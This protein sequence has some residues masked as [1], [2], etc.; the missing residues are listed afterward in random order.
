MKQAKETRFISKLNIQLIGITFLI[1]SI[2]IMNFY[3]ASQGQ[4]TFWMHTLWIFMGIILFFGL[5]SFN[6]QL[7]PRICYFFYG[8]NVLALI[9]VLFI[10]SSSHGSQRW[11]DLGLFSFQPSETMKIILIC[12]LAHLLSKN[13]TNQVYGF[14]DVI[15]PSIFVLPPMILIA[16][17]PDLG[18]ALIIGIQSLIVIF[19][20]KLNRNLW[21]S[22]GVLIVI[23]VPIMWNFA[24]KDYQKSRV[25]TFLSSQND[26]SGSSYNIIQSKI[27]IGSGQV[28]GKGLKKGTQTQLRFIPE[29]QTDFI[30]SVLSEEHGFIGSIIVL[31]LFLII[32]LNI[33]DTAGQSRDKLGVFICI[34]CASLVFCQVLINVGM[35][36][37]LFPVVGIPLPLLSYG[38]SNMM[39]IFITLGLVSSVYTHKF[40]YSP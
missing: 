4:S 33:L 22:L 38:G 11:F 26:P 16:L 27:A 32:L 1:L 35:T 12:V 17:Q 14:K 23:A 8:L 10:G 15:F 9:L 30:F 6:Y 18:T 40:I 24:L 28:F 34:G 36:I 31:F 2:S 39:T 37:G 5:T 7:I 25:L 13:P 19:F 3:S 21:I 29:R 20:L